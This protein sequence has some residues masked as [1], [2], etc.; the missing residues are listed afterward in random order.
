M[1][2]PNVR[3]LSNLPI[4][5]VRN[6]FAVSRT[7]SGY[8][9]QVWVN[10]AWSSV[11]VPTSLGISVFSAGMRFQLVFSL[12]VITAYSECHTLGMYLLFYMKNS[13]I[14]LGKWEQS[15]AGKFLSLLFPKDDILDKSKMQNVEFKIILKGLWVVWVESF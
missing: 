11:C 6:V 4:A 5:Y 14:H 13:L 3:T 7:V 15:S 2:L 10:R 8:R 12:W 9:E 1:W